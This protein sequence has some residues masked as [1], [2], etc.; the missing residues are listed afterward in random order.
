MAHSYD[1]IVV[2]GPT[3]SGKTS[4]AAAVADRLGGEVVSADSRQVYRDMDIGT[5]KDYLDYIVDG[6]LVPC[7]MVDIIDAGCRYNVFEYQRDFLRV[8]EDLKVRGVLPVVC[9]GSG[10]YLDSIV[11]GYRLLPV[12]VNEELRQELSG[13]SLERLREILSGYKH[14]H[15]DT[16]VDNKKRAIRA[17]EIESYYAGRSPEEV[18]FPVISPLITAIQYDR[19]E[20]R[21]R[22]SER[23]KQRL[24]EGMIEEVEHLL[25]T[26]VP[27]ETLL[28]YGLEYKFV[29]RYLTDSISYEEMF[30]GLETSIHQFA[31]RQMTWFR[32]MERRGIK[33][34]WIAGDLSSAEKTDTIIQLYKQ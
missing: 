29:T 18:S 21:K 26:G 9:G 4:V 5:G 20:R 31:K 2:T 24:K 30:H 8:Y 32:G 15:N 16:D 14:L 17:I 23:L 1:L 13:L 25:A 19:N 27:E 6:R 11:S 28:Y 12:P 7:H 10:M 3:A 33:I 22:I 34:H